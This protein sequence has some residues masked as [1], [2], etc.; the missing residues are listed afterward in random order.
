M[1]AE[2]DPVRQSLRSAV[3]GRLREAVA[4]VPDPQPRPATATAGAVAT[5][6][7]EAADGAWAADAADETA[8]AALR[9][10]GAPAF[11]APLSAGGLALGLA[12][13]TA[14]AEELGRAALSG[15]YLA[16]AFAIDA[17]ATGGAP[18]SPLADLVA[19]DLVVTLAG[20]DHD[21]PPVR[22]KET[23]DGHLELTGRLALEVGT[24]VRTGAVLAPVE[25][26][27]GHLA[28]TM[29]ELSTVDPATVRIDPVREPSGAAGLLTLAGTRCAESAVLCTWDR[30]PVP[31]G[32]LGRA[33]IRQAAFLLGLA[34]GALA[35][36]ACYTTDRH[37][38]GQPLRDFQS[39]A[40]R[41]AARYTDLEAL[42]LAVARATSLADA[43]QPYGPA[44]AEVLAQAAETAAT[45]VQTVLQV[46]GV[47]GMT[48][49]LGVH[50][51]YLRARQET[52]RLGTPGT[53]WRELGLHRLRQ[54][55]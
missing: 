25:L 13:S 16:V 40:F 49:E 10:L 44:A 29:L 22:A 15:R 48:G 55:L 18:A 9:E 2:P 14:V 12:A 19:G 33:R 31:A 11:D 3:R 47:R 35:I 26:A 39:V 43:E 52:R 38:F 1:I 20:F 46:C 28:A 41:L 27:G 8:W 51:H 50:R 7:G 42:R 32:V 37:Q 17:A 30:S 6:G 36:G 54:S 5:N 23:G 45:T 53:R 34:H 24:D 21:H 4:L